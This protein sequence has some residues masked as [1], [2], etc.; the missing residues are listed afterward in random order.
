MEC[1]NLCRPDHMQKLLATF[2]EVADASVKRQ[3]DRKKTKET[4]EDYDPSIDGDDEALEAESELEYE[5]WSQ[6]AEC[7]SS[8]LKEYREHVVPM[9]EHLNP[10]LLPMLLEAERQPDERRVAISIFDDVAE[11]AGVSG[12][13]NS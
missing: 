5:I 8:L 13:A 11:H 7:M 10:Y 3:N 1:S 12:G 6:I 9:V 2:K 4:S